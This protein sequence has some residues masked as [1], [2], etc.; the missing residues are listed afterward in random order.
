MASLNY[1]VIIF[2]TI[3]KLE[4]KLVIY[5]VSKTVIRNNNKWIYIARSC[6]KNRKCAV[7]DTVVETE[8]KDFWDGD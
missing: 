2:N 8:Q 4:Y 1:T 7:D 3:P 5:A 6:K